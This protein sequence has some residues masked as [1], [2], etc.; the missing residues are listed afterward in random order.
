MSILKIDI[1]IVPLFFQKN[2][3]F[4]RYERRDTLI[5]GRYHG[6]VLS[7][8]EIYGKKQENNQTKKL[9]FTV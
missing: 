8:C 5:S 3:L 4:K 7:A 1:A 6:S 2:H 9:R